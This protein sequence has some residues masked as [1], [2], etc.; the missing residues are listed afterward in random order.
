MRRSK[1]ENAHQGFEKSDLV[2]RS[3]LV[4]GDISSVSSARRTRREA[5]GISLAIELL[6]LGLLVAAPLFTSVAQPY[7]RPAQPT[8]F[9]FFRPGPPP[10]LGEQ[11]TT[12][13][14]NHIQKIYDPYSPIAPVHPTGSIRSDEPPT[15][16]EP[17][18]GRVGDYI[19]GG[20][21]LMGSQ[22]IQIVREPPA[23]SQPTQQEKHPVKVS[24]GVLQAQLITR[25]EPRYPSLALQT[26][27][28][29]VVRLHAIISRDGRI[30]SLDILSGHP[31]LVKAA[32]EA[33]SQW[34]YRPTMLNGE[35][36][37]VETSI[38]V[39]FQLHN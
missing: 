16:S 7:L 21:S 35:P 31:L 36:V 33:V 38:T 5:F 28:E 12:A 29:G 22:A 15:L 18:L 23:V 19:P 32:L 30:T 8:V 27:T 34:R 14:A 4:D 39:I 24:E 10:K 6:I 9:T 20:E 3:C 17:D 1:P 11:V 2:L 13:V 37:E 26:K 25:V